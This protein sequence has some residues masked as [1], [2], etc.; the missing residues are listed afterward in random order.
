[1]VESSTAL[2]PSIAALP[3]IDPLDVREGDIIFCSRPGFLQ[4]LC[5]TAGELWRHVGIA[6]TIQTDAGEEMGIVEVDGDRFVTRPLSA[7]Q[8]GYRWLA[9]GR[10][11]DEKGV[12]HAVDW[13]RYMIGAGQAY[14]WDDAV[15]AGFV[16]LT[17]FHIGDV[18]PELAA[19]VV[20]RASAAASPRLTER[21]ITHTCS[22]FI[23]FAFNSGDAQNRLVLDLEVSQKVAGDVT[24][25]DAVPSLRAGRGSRIDRQQLLEAAR[26]V[27]GA[28]G[29]GLSPEPMSSE[30][31]GRWAM[32]GDIWRSP[33]I[34]FRGLLPTTSAD[35]A[36]SE[37]GTG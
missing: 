14:A 29:G 3:L 4:R 30:T 17:R 7:V 21:R 34:D 15:V 33:S 18:D 32:P 19:R 25:S 10:V 12:T 24:I 31:Q 1:M 2:P 6:L 11:A 9:V 23:Y 8:S 26:V 13:A 37:G 27:V 16:A 36:Q 28:V 35:Q 5:S 20:R 22:S